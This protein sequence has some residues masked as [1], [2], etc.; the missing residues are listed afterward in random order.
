MFGLNENN[1][2]NNVFIDTVQEKETS[3]YINMK[4]FQVT[5][6]FEVLE[7]SSIIVVVLLASVFQ[8]FFLYMQEVFCEQYYLLHLNINYLLLYL[9]EFSV[10]K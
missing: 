5:H 3:K 2:R 6:F 4:Y 8:R 1:K 10:F 9:D 7:K